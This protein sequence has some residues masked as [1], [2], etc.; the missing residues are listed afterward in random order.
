VAPADYV[1]RSGVISF[2]PGATSRSVVITV[3]NDTLVEG[4][5]IANVTL[6]SPVGASL[7][8][9]PKATLRIADNDGKT[10]FLSMPRYTVSEAGPM[11]TFAV[12]RSGALTGA[13]TV[14]VSTENITATGG[15]GQDYQR[16][17]N[18]L[19]TIPATKASVNVN[20][21]ITDDATDEPNET[22]RLRLSSPTGAVLGTQNPAIV[23]IVDN[24]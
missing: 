10:V 6:S 23:T 5:E 2:A 19:V 20:V 8:S 22:F 14:K 12:Q 17:V 9:I 1:A 3:K 16:L 7:G 15:P 13:V 18:K 21:G 24:D 11:L 4:T